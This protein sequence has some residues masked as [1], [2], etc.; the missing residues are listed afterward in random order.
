METSGL[1]RMDHGVLSRE[2]VKISYRLERKAC[3]DLNSFGLC[4]MTICHFERFFTVSLLIPQLV[5]D[6]LQN[7][8]GDSVV[9]NVAYKTIPSLLLSHPPRGSNTSLPP[10]LSRPS[11]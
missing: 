11:C 8:P 7:V 6:T 4:K 2:N 9:G 10:T 1:R 3:T 5:S